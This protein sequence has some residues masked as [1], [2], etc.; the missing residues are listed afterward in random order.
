[1]GL[2]KE[3]G[4]L[5]GI[6]TGGVIGGTISLVGD[7]TESRFIK[8]IGEGIYSASK[9]TGKLVG[10]VADGAVGVVG[11]VI[12]SDSSAVEVGFDQ[13]GDAT[14][15]TLC[16]IGQGINSVAKDGG[17]LVSGILEGNDDKVLNAS[18]NLVKTAAIS[19]FAIGVADSVGIVGQDGSGAEKIEVH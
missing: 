2:F 10:Q 17:D 16:G 15:Q 3:L 11:G 19:V 13:L 4:N 6:V 9:N 7:V 1:L 12:L 8:E 14:K 5:A 18:K